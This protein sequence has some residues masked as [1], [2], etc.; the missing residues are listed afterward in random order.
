M[1]ANL[2]HITLRRPVFDRDETEESWWDY[3]NRK[4]SGL[5]NYAGSGQD[6]LI[7]LMSEDIG[8]AGG[9]VHWCCEL[10]F[11]K[12][13]VPEGTTD[14]L[15]VNFSVKAFDFLSEKID[16]DLDNKFK[17]VV[18]ADFRNFSDELGRITG[19][20]L[21]YLAVLDGEEFLSLEEKQKTLLLIDDLDSL[22]ERTEE[23][24]LKKQNTE[25]IAA[26]GKVARDAD[27]FGL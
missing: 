16:M 1:H 24:L 22:L 3:F 4:L 19:I 12:A 7:T 6:S 21:P 25:K 15:R 27:G 10:K 14:A 18:E 2:E 23:V 5:P 9:S 8:P 26:G 11:V 17:S 20:D 13:S